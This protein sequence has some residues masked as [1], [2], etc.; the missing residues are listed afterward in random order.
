VQVSHIT[1]VL[2]TP[3]MWRLAQFIRQHP[4]QGAESAPDLERFEQELHD[5]VMALERDLLGDDRDREAPHGHPPPTPPGI[6]V[7]YHGGSIEL[8]PRC[9]F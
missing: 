9:R 2:Q 1:D 4:W 3:A 8:S 5:H 6:R 7:S